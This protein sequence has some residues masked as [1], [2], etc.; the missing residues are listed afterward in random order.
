MLVA[1]CQA[2]VFFC[3]L[4]YVFRPCMVL[5]KTMQHGSTCSLYSA[6]ELSNLLLRHLPV[7]VAVCRAPVFF[8]LLAYVFRP[9]MV[10]RKTMQHGSTCSLYSAKELSN[11]LLR[12]LK[13]LLLE[14]AR[15]I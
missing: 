9:C 8:C 4:A 3:L 12:H 11:L 6:K 2:P 7:L 13:T 1:V 5:H 10:L 15:R 14:P